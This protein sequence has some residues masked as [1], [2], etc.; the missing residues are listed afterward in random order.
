MKSVGDFAMGL[1][2][3]G[4]GRWLTCGRRFVVREE[5]PFLVWGKRVGGCA[6]LMMLSFPQKS[7]WPEA[8]VMMATLFVC[9]TRHD[10]TDTSGYTRLNRGWNSVTNKSTMDTREEKVKNNTDRSTASFRLWYGN[11]ALQ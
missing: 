10:R 6:A 9:R 1:R 3:E 4:G 2:G 7:A 8:G 5:G 11:I